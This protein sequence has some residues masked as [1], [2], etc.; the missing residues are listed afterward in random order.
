VE[1]VGPSFILFGGSFALGLGIAH[2]RARAKAKAS[3][4]WPSTL[5][6]VI[7]SEVQEMSDSEGSSYKPVVVY[8]YSVKGREYEGQRIRF[9]NLSSGQAK[10]RAIRDRY[11]FGSNQAVR[12]NPE[13]PEEATLE[14]TGPG[15]TYLILAVGGLFFFCMGIAIVSGALS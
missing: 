1:I 10:A 8:R 14:T 7:S 15:P 6:E 12:Y 3:A 5:G 2:A 4:S 11:P 13:K 9:G